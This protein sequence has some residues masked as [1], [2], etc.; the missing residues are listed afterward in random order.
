MVEIGLPQNKFLYG[1]EAIQF[2]AASTLVQMGAE[3]TE[4]VR[5]ASRRGGATAHRATAV[6]FLDSDPMTTPSLR[7]HQ[8]LRQQEPDDVMSDLGAL[9]TPQS[10]EALAATLEES[11]VQEVSAL[12]EDIADHAEAQR[13]QEALD[14]SEITEAT[15]QALACTRVGD[16]WHAEGSSAGQCGEGEQTE[17]DAMVFM[18]ELSSEGG[19]SRIEESR[20]DQRG[21]R[22]RVHVQ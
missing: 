18:D 11:I 13:V 16:G 17:V 15:R 4:T 2:M 21:S 3:V 8:R 22:A 6:P 20:E 7:L 9:P 19:S 5:Q 10:D 1:V 12:E 14:E